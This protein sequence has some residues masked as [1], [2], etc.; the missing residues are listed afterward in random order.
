M[1]KRIITV[2]LTATLGA[3][4]LAWAHDE[5][6]MKMPQKAA[7][8]EFQQL[9]RLAGNW[10]G[11]STPMGPN[12]KPEILVTEFEVTAAGS[13]IE[14]TLMK[15]TPHEMVDMYTDE[16]GKLAMTN[17]CAMGNHPHM[18]LKQAGPHQITLEMGATPDIDAAK[19][20]HMHS[21]T[22]EFPDA[23]HLIER[24]TNYTNGK[25]GETAVFTLARVK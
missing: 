16:G 20:S 5:K 10:K 14:E 8:P 18:V 13:A 24:W 9:K 3:A 2:A 25:P 11:T 19:D 7:S 23:D 1:N 17:E 15:D 6:E 12:A 22:L 4:V 21:L